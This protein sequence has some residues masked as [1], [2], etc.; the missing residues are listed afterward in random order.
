ML[1]I[2]RIT[3]SSISSMRTPQMT[4]V[5]LLALGGRNGASLKNVS[6]SLFPLICFASA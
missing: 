5:I 6:K 1:R 4:P 3:G 2:F